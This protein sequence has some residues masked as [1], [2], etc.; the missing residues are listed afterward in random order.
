M[1]TFSLSRPGRATCIALALANGWLPLHPARAQA[2]ASAG[3]ALCSVNGYCGSADVSTVTFSSPPPTATT[4]NPASTGGPTTYGVPPSSVSTPAIN[5]P[6]EPVDNGRRPERRDPSGSGL[7]PWLIGTIVVA[8]IIAIDSTN[9]NWAKPK[10]LDAKGPRFPKQQPFGR[11]QVQGYA[12]A[13]W[14]VMLD[15]STQ[16]GTATWLE[17]R[18]KGQ[19]DRQGLALPIPAGD[20]RRLVAV[21]IPADWAGGSTQIARYTVKSVTRSARGE[22]AYSPLTVYGIGAGESAV[23]YE[24]LALYA[25]AADLAGSWPIYAQR[26]RAKTRPPAPKLP[27]IALRMPLELRDFAPMEVTQP[28]DVRYALLARRLFHRSV[29]EVLRLPKGNAAPERPTKLDRVR[30]Q[31]LFPLVAGNHPGDWRT[32]GVKPKPRAGRFLMQARAWLVGGRGDEHDW[33]GV[34]APNFVLVR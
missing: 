24:Q 33:T 22:P 9:G 34:F 18:T 15:L 14:P 30:E 29:V 20:G 28:A 3:Q 1:E 19:K 26:N 12:K 2:E 32:M 23:Q 6:A 17:L 4:P 13:G 25:D 8:T 31:R 21:R 7:L 11:F 10:E 27:R 5:V 16:P